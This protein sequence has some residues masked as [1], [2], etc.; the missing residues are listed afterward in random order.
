MKVVLRFIL[1][2]ITDVNECDVIN[3]GCNQICTN[4]NGSYYCRCNAEF[5]LDDDGRTCSG[6]AE[7]SLRTLYS[8]LHE[9]VK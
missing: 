6:K 4:T 7:N 3:G 5:N 2:F 8:H 9:P 1:C